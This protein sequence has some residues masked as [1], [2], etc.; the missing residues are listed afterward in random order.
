MSR[1]GILEAQAGK[2]G[3]VTTLNSLVTQLSSPAGGG[4]AAA[5]GSAALGARPRTGWTARSRL[6]RAVGRL[7]S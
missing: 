6:T 2:Q 1:E 5:V 7:T 3:A 4:R